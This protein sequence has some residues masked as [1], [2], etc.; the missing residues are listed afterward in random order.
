MFHNQTVFH[1]WANSNKY[2]KFYSLCYDSDTNDD[3]N[4]EFLI[5]QPFVI[6]HEKDME[7][8]GKKDHFIL[9]SFIIHLRHKH[10]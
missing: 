6:Q 3:V 2:E 5:S 10:K 8:K 1:N 9:L 4:N 7:E